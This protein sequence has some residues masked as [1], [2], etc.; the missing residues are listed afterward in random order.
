MKGGHRTSL[1]ALSSC[2]ADLCSL[3][4]W[5]MSETRKPLGS[6]A[7]NM[8]VNGRDYLRRRVGEELTPVERHTRA[9]YARREEAWRGLNKQRV[10]A[11][12]RMF[13]LCF[14]ESEN[15]HQL[16]PVTYKLLKKTLVKRIIPWICKWLVFTMDE[17]YWPITREQFQEL[18]RYLAEHMPTIH[19]V[20]E[21][22]TIAYFFKEVEKKREQESSEEESTEEEED[23]G[24]RS[25]EQY[26]Q[27]DEYYR[28]R[29]IC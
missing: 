12:I 17:F 26:R 6:L 27:T 28:D 11:F 20:P 23:A 18:D 25:Y 24:A 2:L 29:D 13:I 5:K 9:M 19:R 21:W 10:A 4:K 22:E 8:N 3:V 16:H 1:L 7:S 14:V 15:G